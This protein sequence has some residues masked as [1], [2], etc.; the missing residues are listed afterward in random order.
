MAKTIG[1]RSELIYFDTQWDMNFIMR[2]TNM[3][4]TIYINFSSLKT[5]T[6]FLNFYLL[7]LFAEESLLF[8]VNN[9]KF[10]NFLKW[11]TCLLKQIKSTFKVSFSEVA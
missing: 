8:S 6:Y 1:K 10:K 11:V 9:L 4:C 2:F 5:E 3:S 7:T